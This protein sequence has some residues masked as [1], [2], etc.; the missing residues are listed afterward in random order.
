VSKLNFGGL[1]TGLSEHEY[2]MTMPQH[3]ERKSNEDDKRQVDQNMPLDWDD[4]GNVSSIG[5]KHEEEM[6][7]GV[8]EHPMNNSQDM[9]GDKEVL[10]S[11]KSV[12]SVPVIKDEEEEE[13][14]MLDMFNEEMETDPNLPA[15]VVQMQK[16]EK[17]TAL[18][19]YGDT[20]GSRKAPVKKKGSKSLPQV[21]K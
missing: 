5:E 9:G 17:V 3:Q 4:D 19:G 15:S 10:G 2:V 21:F 12:E 18:G 11:S 14:G 1:V 6:S 20:S 16:W 13:E 7:R 8:N